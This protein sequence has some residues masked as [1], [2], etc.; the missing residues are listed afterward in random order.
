LMDSWEAVSKKERKLS[1]RF[2]FNLSLEYYNIIITNC[3]HHLSR[4][5]T[6]WTVSNVPY[7]YY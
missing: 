6:I 2:F 7:S 3:H 4:P 5:P 1:R